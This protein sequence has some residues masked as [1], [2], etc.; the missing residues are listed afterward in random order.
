MRYYRVREHDAGAEWPATASIYAADPHEA[1][2]E[3]ARREVARGSERNAAYEKGL[4]LEVREDGAKTS[5]TLVRVTLAWSPSFSSTIK[6]QI[7]IE[8]P[9]S[10]RA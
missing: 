1:A 7:N 10:E 6:S 4:L 5:A 3:H 8:E 2:E 9:A